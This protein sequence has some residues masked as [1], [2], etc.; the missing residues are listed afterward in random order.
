MQL[1]VQIPTGL[2]GGSLPMVVS[3]GAAASQNGVTLSV[4]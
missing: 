2:T 3:F 1:N 4:Q